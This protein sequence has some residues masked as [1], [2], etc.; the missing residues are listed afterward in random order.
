MSVSPNMH[1]EEFLD[2]DRF[3]VLSS[4]LN[5]YAK[6]LSEL[7]GVSDAFTVQN[8]L[9]NA[10]KNADMG[11]RY[12]AIEEQEGKPLG[13]IL[14][15]AFKEELQWQEFP[16][17]QADFQG[18]L[19]N[20]TDALRTK[21]GSLSAPELGRVYA[22]VED[23]A[24]ELW[25]SSM[26]QNEFDRDEVV[27][28]FVDSGRIRKLAESIVQKYDAS[29]LDVN[30]APDALIDGFESIGKAT[31][32]AAIQL[33]AHNIQ[34]E[35]SARDIGHAIEE[36]FLTLIDSEFDQSFVKFM[37]EIDRIKQDHL[38][39]ISSDMAEIGVSDREKYYALAAEIWEAGYGLKEEPSPELEDSLHI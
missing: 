19:S 6:H 20:I 31:G 26:L 30:T 39:K 3:E 10:S 23:L 4:E 36:E 38:D 35:N 25:H 13:A 22:V 37:Q 34:I 14:R 29:G 27:A 8:I 18:I 28:N 32:I 21:M 16:S 1:V 24:D 33:G 11:L 9:S 7:D 5:K 15:D 12:H 2:S 17:N